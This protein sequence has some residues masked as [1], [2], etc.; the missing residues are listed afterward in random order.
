MSAIDRLLY[1]CIPMICGFF[2]FGVC[3]YRSGLVSIVAFK[4]LTF[5]KVV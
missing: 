2:M 1:V 3:C 4:T 5:H